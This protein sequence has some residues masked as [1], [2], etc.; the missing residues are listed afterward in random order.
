MDLTRGLGLRGVQPFP[1]R[2]ESGFGQ[3]RKGQIL[4]E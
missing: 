4:Q 2:G 3:T 1:Q